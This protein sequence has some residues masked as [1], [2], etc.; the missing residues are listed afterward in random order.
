ML[1]LSIQQLSEI[2]HGQLALATMGPVDGDLLS[3]GKVVTDSRK[4]LPGDLFWGLEGSRTNGSEF[5]EEALMRAAQGTIVA[6]RHIE[7]WAGQFSIRVPHAGRALQELGRWTRRHFDA[8]VIATVGEPHSLVTAN[9]THQLLQPL[10]SGSCA[11][12]SVRHAATMA[13]DMLQWNNASAFAIT[14]LGPFEKSEF[15]QISHLC[16][17]QIV[18][19]NS[20]HKTTHQE[21]LRDSKAFAKTYAEFLDTL[22]HDTL[23]VIN[24]DDPW[25]RKAVQQ[26][27]LESVRVGREGHSDVMATNVNCRNGQLAFNVASTR[28]QFPFW[29]R[30]FLPQALAAIAI[31]RLMSVPLETMQELARMAKL[32]Q[33]FG[34]LRPVAG[35]TLI[36]DSRAASPASLA[37]GLESL[38]EIPTPGRR[39]V[40][41]GQLN[42]NKPRGVD[43]CRKVG[44]MMVTRCSSDRLI[45]CGTTA[46]EI[47][48]AA[49][50]AGMPRRST[51]VC[52]TGTAAAEQLANELMPGDIVLLSDNRSAEMETVTRYLTQHRT[53]A[54]A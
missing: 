42:V 16:S 1:D 43:Q 14:D 2:V 21:P 41:C 36:D 33:G 20:P 3:V 27:C 35:I 10:G 39:W 32:P 54:A 37:V 22:P 7:P 49:I 13:L 38:S 51:H 46:E 25:L 31:G 23:V 30:H 15:L 19:I 17:P 5:A 18:A 4:V 6:G 53:Y 52:S 26:S 47:A 11:D 44:R 24:G 8:P 34:D 45:C 48:N 28:F 40:I 50:A 29:G 9:L 12:T